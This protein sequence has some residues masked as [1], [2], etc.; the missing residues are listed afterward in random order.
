[1][2]TCYCDNCYCN[3]SK[4]C[5]LWCDCDC[6]KYIISSDTIHGRIIYR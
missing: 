5:Q 2:N 1:M 4:L 6:C 3:T